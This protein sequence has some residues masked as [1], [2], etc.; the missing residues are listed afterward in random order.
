MQKNLRPSIGKRAQ[1]RPEQACPQASR[2]LPVAARA[3]PAQGPSTPTN[4]WTRPKM[5][6]LFAFQASDSPL[7]QI[8]LAFFD[9]GGH[10][11]EGSR[12]VTTAVLVGAVILA[13]I[14]WRRFGGGASWNRQSG[15]T[16]LPREISSILEQAMLLRSR[17][18]MSFTPSPPPARPSR[19]RSSSWPIRASPWRCPSE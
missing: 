16:V 4:P 1:G 9:S 14:I 6:D 15:S 3:I 7:R 5:I 12:I 8:S 2:A 10:Q 18:D 11:P 19:A 13:Y 17:I